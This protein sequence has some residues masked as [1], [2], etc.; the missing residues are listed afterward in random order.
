MLVS[1]WLRTS[2]STLGTLIHLL[3]GSLPSS[4]EGVDSVVDSGDVTRLVRKKL[5]SVLIS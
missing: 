4:V 2:L 1:T 3:R 5:G